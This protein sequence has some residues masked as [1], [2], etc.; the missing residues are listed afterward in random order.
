[1]KKNYFSPEFEEI[2]IDAILLSSTSPDSDTTDPVNI[3]T[4]PDEGDFTW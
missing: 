2:K 1:M 4:N 3:V